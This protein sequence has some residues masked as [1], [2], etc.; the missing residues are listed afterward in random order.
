MH[1]IKSAWAPASSPLRACSPS[2]PQLLFML[3]TLPHPLP[4]ASCLFSIHPFTRKICTDLCTWSPGV[5]RCSHKWSTGR[6]ADWA[7]INR[8]TG[9]S[10]PQPWPRPWPDPPSQTCKWEER[11]RTET[12]NTGIPDKKSCVRKGTGGGTQDQGESSRRGSRLTGGTC[13]I[14][15]QRGL[16]RELAGDPPT[17]LVQPR[18]PQAPAGRRCGLLSHLCQ[19]QLPSWRQR[20]WSAAASHS[21]L[22]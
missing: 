7:E 13:P 3:P 5:L 11:S 20:G 9:S 6:L 18:P 2:A 17:S 1:L 4:P 14:Q 19:P 15:P 21:E 8:L 12:Q 22:A 16:C 10:L